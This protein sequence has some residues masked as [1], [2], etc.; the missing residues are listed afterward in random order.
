MKPI[1]FNMYL[2]SWNFRKTREW[3]QLADEMGFYSVSFGDHFYMNVTQGGSVGQTASTPN[4]E[5][6][7]A[8][9]AVAAITRRV[10]L[11]TAVTP[12]GFRNPAVLGKIT[13][14][15]DHI[16]EGRLIVGLGAG[17]QRSEYEAYNL[18]YPS[19]PIRLRELED[20]IK[21]LKVMWTEPEPTYHGTDFKIDKAYNYPQPTQKPHPPIMVGGGGKK[22]IGIAGRY[23]DILSLVPPNPDGNP[24]LHRT[25]TFSRQQFRERVDLFYDHARKAGRDPARLEVSTLSYLLMSNDKAQADQMLGASAQAASVDIE[26]ARQALTYV[27]GTPAE[28]RREIRSRYEQLDLSYFSLYFSSREMLNTFAR[29]VMPEFAGQ[30]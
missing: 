16:S 21:L 27:S 13:A 1:R 14:T 9:G 8:L 18:P 23:A 11:L 4:L 5:C 26:T 10:K 29:E 19:N 7:T 15:L 28:V 24:D 17:W 20:A 12:I 6:Y 3:A 2:P 22:V 30:S 25:L